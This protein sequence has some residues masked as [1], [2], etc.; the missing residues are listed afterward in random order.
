VKRKYWIGWSQPHDKKPE[1]YY[2]IVVVNE[3]ELMDAQARISEII[4]EDYIQCVENEEV[5]DET[6]QS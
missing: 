4:A 5:E 1:D 6:D 2:C 3:E